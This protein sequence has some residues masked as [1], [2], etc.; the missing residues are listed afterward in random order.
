[1]L[2]SNQIVR[3]VLFSW[4][5]SS[6]S[7]LRVNADDQD[8]EF[9]RT[10]VVPILSKRCYECHS[11]QSGTMEGGLTLDWRNG[12]IVGG[13]RG[14]TIVPSKPEASLLI[15]AISHDSAELKMP[16]E[17][18]SSDEIAIL[19]K[20][21]ASGAYDDRV[22]EPREATEL[23]RDW[24]S[25]KPLIQPSIP[26]NNERNPIDA[27]VVAKLQPMSMQL[28]ERA[29]PR[30][31]LR[32]LKWD[33]TG[34]PAS[35]DEIKAFESEPSDEHYH[36]WVDRCLESPQ[37][38][39]RWARHWFDT[40]HY[41]ES[42]GFEHD[43]GR[44]NAWHFR[45]YV[46]DALNDDKSWNEFIEDQLAADVIHPDQPWRW[47]GLGFIGAGPFDWSAFTTAPKTFENIDRDDM[48]TQTMAAFCSTTANC[49]R[50][51]AHKF[52]PISQEDYYGLQS[53]FAG[54][55]KGDI[56]VESDPSVFA[57]RMHWNSLIQFAEQ[58][59]PAMFNDMECLALSDQWVSQRG[60]AN[61]WQIAKVETFH[62]TNGSELNRN[63]DGSFTAKLTRPEADT[64]SFTIPMNGETIGAIRLEVMVDDSLP[65]L[66]PGRADNGNLHLSE[67]EAYYFSEQAVAPERIP[68]RFA[69]ADFDQEGWGILRAI[70]A[71]PKTAW[72]IY[73]SVGR[74]HSAVFELT[75][76]L[77]SVSNSRLLIHLKQL[78]GGSHLIGRCRLSFSNKQGEWVQ[79]IPE[80]VQAALDVSD[81][82]RTQ[83]Q[84]MTL[85]QHAVSVGA[86]SRLASLPKPTST[87]AVGTVVKIPAG[88]GKFEA[89]RLEKPSVV[90]VLSRGDIDKPKSVANPG[91][92]AVLD[93]VP[94]SNV[95]FEGQPESKRREALA[96]WIAH[97]ENVLTWRSAVNRVWHY[98]FGKGLCDTPSDF[99]RMGGTPSNPELLDWLAVW[100]RDE[101][102]G[103]LKK[104]HRLICTSE[105][106]RQ[107]S[108]VRSASKGY[109]LDSDN[110]WMWR[111]NRAR[112]DAEGFRDF[113]LTS[114]DQLD[115]TMHGPSIQH[116]L[117][118]KGPQA[119]PNLDY[120]NYD[121]DT[122]GATRRSIYRYVWRGIADPF[123]ESLDFPDLGL[124]SP[125]RSFSASP[126]Q[127]LAIYNNDFVLHFSSKLAESVSAQQSEVR[128]QL[129]IVMRKVLARDLTADE[130]SSFEQ[131]VSK[132][133]LAGLV[134]VLF[135]SNEFVFVD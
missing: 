58:R 17:K 69:T 31:Q 104:L 35:F 117:Q 127:A 67:F 71:D 2:S 108:K 84:N 38:G 96:H 92:L 46:I 6:N 106:Y 132:H 16:E 87:Y 13:E 55:L 126:V 91:A 100:F 20:W 115:T 47:R 75:K 130:L 48:V 86:K 50:C 51:H 94:F 121:W 27:F 72:G 61:E 49:A 68:F 73:P 90:H 128:A 24:W 119:T 4:M 76:P 101:A 107:S 125:A 41:A 12:W 109:E 62:S 103:S 88:E 9:F 1:M 89:R 79:A 7:I 22:K 85:M 11:H 93:D 42:H 5:I 131:Y 99:G 113:V 133:S 80:S 8:A 52:D 29:T 56:D 135:N 60:N 77:A 59:S 122:P 3:I 112:I 37:L 39:E 129:S 95:S 33:L 32:R 98:H 70:D 28:S 21:V 82:Q 74:S 43:I 30:E 102:K 63:S 123:M 114:S 36:E 34:L 45:D 111:Q 81:E 110:R 14:Q 53:V 134:R 18:L 26:W 10:Q 19:T 65:F 118:S 116:F 83:E 105:V 120:V 15:K 23:S 64:Y 78:H 97:R 40:I 44:D 25:L 54:V 124:L 66:G 57:Q